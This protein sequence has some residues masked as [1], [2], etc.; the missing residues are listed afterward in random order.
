VD[1]HPLVLGNRRSLDALIATHSVV[2]HSESN[3]LFVSQGPALTG[4]YF[5][6]DLQQS[7]ADGRPIRTGKIEPDQR[8]NPEQFTTVRRSF[9][10]LSQIRQTLQDSKDQE[11]CRGVHGSLLALDPSISGHPDYLTALGDSL[12]C[13]GETDSAQQAWSHALKARPAYSRKVTALKERLNL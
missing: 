8:V 2:Y 13:M 10:Q 5:G 11:I 4:P 3:Q 12:N 1:D 7:F 9:K 6:Y